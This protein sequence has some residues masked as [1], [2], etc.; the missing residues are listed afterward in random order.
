MP[1]GPELIC[2][3][4]EAGADMI[5]SVN[6]ENLPWWG[7]GWQKRAYRQWSYRDPDPS[8]WRRT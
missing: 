1:F 6:G 8:P 2:A 7:A 3:G 4:I 5:L